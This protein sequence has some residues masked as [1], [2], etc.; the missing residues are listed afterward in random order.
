MKTKM[1]IPLLLLVVSTHLKAQHKLTKLW[2]S[3][4]TLAVPESVLPVQ[5]GLYVSLVDGQALDAD[6]KGGIAKLDLDGKIINAAWVTG[7]NA[8]KG[9]GIWR[10]HLY[11]SNISEIVVI[12]TMTA[13][14]ISRIPVPGAK[15]LNDITV[16]DKGTVYVSDSELGNI[17]RIFN[18]QVSLYLKD[19]PGANGLKAVGEDLYILTEQQVLKASPDRRLLALGSIPQKGADGIEPVGNGDFL[20]TI[21]SGLIYYLDR[22]GKAELLLDTQVEKKSSADIGYDPVHEILYVPT[23]F[24]KSVVAYKLQ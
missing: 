9:M 6:G 2:E 1:L 13:Q 8:P 24:T 21:Y 19:L 17:H 5:D 16:D 14:I 7:L 3:D 22:S 18:G 15:G 23:L 20:F 10:G 11:V 4:T 12:D